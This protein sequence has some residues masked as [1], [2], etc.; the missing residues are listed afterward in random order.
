MSH[1]ATTIYTLRSFPS[2][3]VSTRT[4][5]KTLAHST[6]YSMGEWV[7]G[8]VYSTKKIQHLRSPLIDL[9]LCSWG[10]NAIRVYVHISIHIHRFPHG[11]QHL[12]IH[13]NR[14]IHIHIDT[15]VHTY[16]YAC[17]DLYMQKRMYTYIY[18]Y[19]GVDRER[20]REKKKSSTR[21]WYIC[22]I[23]VLK[24]QCLHTQT[25]MCIYIYIYTCMC[26][27]YIAFSKPIQQCRASSKPGEL[28]LQ[29]FSL[30]RCSQGASTPGTLKLL[31]TAT[32]DVG[33]I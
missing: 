20:E 24:P 21:F 18:M 9:F 31:R 30:K 15:D 17:T 6:W 33:S 11:H 23:C 32:S 22:E 16:T 1:G 3:D 27:F 28:R 19:I 13:I 14:H 25:H 5:T 12:H 26:V 4:I 2:T 8:D 29:G 7:A 10:R